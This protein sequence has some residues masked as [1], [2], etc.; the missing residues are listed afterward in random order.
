M[1]KLIH[2]FDMNYEN[3]LE[4]YN[5]FEITNYSDVECHAIKQVVNGQQKY[6]D[7]I[8]NCSTNLYY[9]VDDDNEDY[10]IGFGSI[11]DTK[12]YD[13]HKNYDAGNIE[14]GIRPN[15][16]RK[17]YGTTLLSMLIDKCEEKGMSDVCVS[18]LKN[19][20]ASKRIILKNNAIFEKEFYDE[21]LGSKGLKFWIKLKPNFKS[22]IIRQIKRIN[23][24]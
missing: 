2:A 3:V 7:Y 20:I 6:I 17:G 10:I 19:N 8:F 9:L 5:S 15:E 13:C 14:Y 22:R 16:R 23:K 11:Q 18:C 24:E 21:F 1:L 4:Y 12:I